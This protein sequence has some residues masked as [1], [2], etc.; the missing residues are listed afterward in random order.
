MH[1]LHAVMCAYVCIYI[2]IYIYIYNICMYTC[3][4]L[5]TDRLADL[6]T[7]LLTRASPL[8]LAWNMNKE[9]LPGIGAFVN[10]A[11]LLRRRATT[12]ARLRKLLTRSTWSPTPHPTPKAKRRKAHDAAH[13]PVFQAPLEPVS[14]GNLESYALLSFGY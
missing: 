5:P 13:L 3:N 11:V 14:A 7:D 8:R 12:T 4:V 6:F 1:I 2:Y 9:L 10:S